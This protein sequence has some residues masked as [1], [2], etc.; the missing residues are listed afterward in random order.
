MVITTVWEYPHQLGCQT[1]A[2]QDPATATDLASF[3]NFFFKKSVSELRYHPVNDA[4][5]AFLLICFVSAIMLGISPYT[6]L[7]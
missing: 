4:A 3:D 2:L 7:Q 6:A 5:A 1:L